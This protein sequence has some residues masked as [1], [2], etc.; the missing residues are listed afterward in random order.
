MPKN[1]RLHEFI[2]MLAKP[3]FSTCQRWVAHVNGTWFDGG[4]TRNSSSAT[5]EALATSWSPVCLTS[6]KDGTHGELAPRLCGV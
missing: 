6:R 5:I 2:Y 4:P 1:D 3:N